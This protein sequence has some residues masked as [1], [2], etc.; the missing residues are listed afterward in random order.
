MHIEM[1]IGGCAHKQMWFQMDTFTQ[2]SIK[3]FLHF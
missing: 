1:R 2:F 3:V